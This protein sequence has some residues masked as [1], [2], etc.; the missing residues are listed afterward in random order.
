[1]DPG[2]NAIPSNPGTYSHGGARPSG[3][4]QKY[5]QKTSQPKSIQISKNQPFDVE[6]SNF[7]I[8]LMSFGLSFLIIFRDHLNLLNC[9]TYN[10][11]PFFQQFP[12]SNFGIKKH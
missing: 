2:P 6:Y 3:D 7:D 9:N 12:D 11:K 1:M 8:F 5:S 10:A 4:P